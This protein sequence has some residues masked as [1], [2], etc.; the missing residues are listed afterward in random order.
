MRFEFAACC[1]PI[2]DYGTSRGE[3]GVSKFVRIETAADYLSIA[4]GYAK[5]CSLLAIS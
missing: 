3:T 4:N 5:C 1:L 2:F